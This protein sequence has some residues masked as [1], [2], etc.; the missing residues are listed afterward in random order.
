MKYGHDVPRSWISDFNITHRHSA[1]T[2]NPDQAQPAKSDETILKEH[3]AFK[4]FSR[5]IAHRSQLKKLNKKIR[6]FQI[7]VAGCFAIIPAATGGLA[8]LLIGVIISLLLMSFRIE[9]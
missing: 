9:L 7:S 1:D 2:R 6:I 5:Q 3:F 8:G 4:R